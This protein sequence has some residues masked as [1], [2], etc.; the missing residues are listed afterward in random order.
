VINDLLLF[1]HVD[2]A[3]AEFLRTPTPHKV[4]K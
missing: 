3:I 2:A 1:E 4:W